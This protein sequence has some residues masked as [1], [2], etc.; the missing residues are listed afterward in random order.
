M[1]TTR[2]PLSM[3]KG[4]F[5]LLPVDNDWLLIGLVKHLKGRPI[6]LFG[7]ADTDQLQQRLIRHGYL[8]AVRTNLSHQSLPD[9]GNKGGGH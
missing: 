8:L 2:T 3:I 6:F 7:S 5:L 1:E 9:D 4:Y